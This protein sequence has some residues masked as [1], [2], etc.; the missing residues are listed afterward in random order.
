M[1]KNNT[2]FFCDYYITKHTMIRMKFL[3]FTHTIH[4][5]QQLYKT[6]IFIKNLHICRMIS[7]ASI[8]Y[9]YVMYILYRPC[10]FWASI[11]DFAIFRYHYIY[12]ISLQLLYVLY[13]YCIE[14]IFTVRFILLLY[15]VYIYCTSYIFNSHFS[16]ILLF[17]VEWSKRKNK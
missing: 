5:V 17:S 3:N 10:K 1:S 11:H 15:K 2:Y 9:V 7:T 12:S 13:C 4:T 6:Y 16:T 14:C 8:H